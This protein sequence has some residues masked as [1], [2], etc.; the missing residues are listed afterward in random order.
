M[1][2][3]KFRVGSVIACVAA[4]MA[5]AA[6]AAQAAVTVLTQA[7]SPVTPTAAYLNGTVSA[8]SRALSYYFEYGLA[9]KAGFSNHSATA[10]I[11]TG[12]TTAFPVLGEIT[13][14]KPKTKYKFE[15]V[16]TT[17]ATAYTAPSTVTGRALTFTTGGAGKVSLTSTKLKVKKG[18]VVVKF[19]CASALTCSG[20][21]KITARDAATKKTLACGSAS[22][23]IESGD[24][25]TV[26]TSKVSKSCAALL[27]A[28]PSKK[29]TAKLTAKFTTLQPKLSKTV[30]LTS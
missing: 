20:K 19:K 12:N 16:V 5:F 10:S 30:G 21:V 27:S 18:R 2:L 13:G 1:Q 9:S 28:A 29:I 7:A 23:T 26:K 15:L 22:V 14:L 8:G 25:L 3:T 11:G 6:G 17:A 24:K 4:L